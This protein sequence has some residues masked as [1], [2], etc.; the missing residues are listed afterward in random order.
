MARFFRLPHSISRSTERFVFLCICVFLALHRYCIPARFDSA[1]RM[2]TRCEALAQPVRSCRTNRNNLDANWITEQPQDHPK[3]VIER[4]CVPRWSIPL[5]ITHSPAHLHEWLTRE[6]PYGSCVVS[7]AGSSCE[8]DG[9]CSNYIVYRRVSV[10]FEALGHC[11]GHPALEVSPKPAD[12]LCA[13]KT[14]IPLNLP[15]ALFFG[16]LDTVFTKLVR[17]ISHADHQ[18]SVIWIPYHWSFSPL[19]VK[20]LTALGI[21]YI[22]EY[23]RGVC[24]AKVIWVCHTVSFDPVAAVNISSVL[25]SVVVP[26]PTNAVVASHRRDCEYVYFTRRSDS[27]RNGRLLPNEEALVRN[28]ASKMNLCVMTGSEPF[29]HVAAVVGAAEG[30]IGSHGAALMNMFWLNPDKQPIVVELDGYKKYAKYWLIATALGYRYAWMPFDPQKGLEADDL[31]KLI[32]SVKATTPTQLP[33]P[34]IRSAQPN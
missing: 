10:P 27:A 31:V 22:T 21:E 14:F 17:V 4:T 23:P 9:G 32:Q 1:M 15:E 19:V 11:G 20:L 26:P 18:N 25:R 3:V 34:R 30:I 33:R 2:V 28:L 24:F 7:P 13:N 5:P 29:L 6:R 12:T 8:Y 16:H